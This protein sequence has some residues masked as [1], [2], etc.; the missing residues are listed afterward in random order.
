MN[1]RATDQRNWRIPGIGA[2]LSFGEDGAGEV[3]LLSANGNVYR[4]K[5]E[6]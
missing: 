1:G 5:A 3:Y 6:S 2:V 4:L